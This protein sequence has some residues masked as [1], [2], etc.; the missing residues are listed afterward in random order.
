MQ[1]VVA[2]RHKELIIRNENDGVLA[3][4]ANRNHGFLYG[5]LRSEAL[6][7]AD[8]GSRW[9]A[10]RS[11][12]E[13]KNRSGAKHE[14]FQLLRA[15]PF[16]VGIDFETLRASLDLH[17]HGAMNR[18]IEYPDMRNTPAPPRHAQRHDH[19][20]WPGK[21]FPQRICRPVLVPQAPHPYFLGFPELGHHSTAALSAEQGFFDTTVFDQSLARRFVVRKAEIDAAIS[22]NDDRYRRV[23]E[24]Q[25]EAIF[26][27]AV[28]EWTRPEGKRPR[29]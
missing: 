7:N 21:E 29:V 6:A 17:N 9:D 18:P 8:C 24:R 12:K 4:G 27:A 1:A 15:Q 11:A 14:C 5:F 28:A 20:G 25:V 13:C 19:F 3:T 10:I 23:Y 16:A 22:R 2:M 26:D